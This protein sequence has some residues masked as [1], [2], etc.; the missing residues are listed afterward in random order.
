[1]ISIFILGYPQPPLG[2]PRGRGREPS[3]DLVLCYQKSYVI[4]IQGFSIVGNSK[5][6]SIFILG[7]PQPPLGRPWGRGREPRG[8]LFLYYQKSCVILIQGFSIV[9]NSKMISIFILGYPK[10]K[11][12][13]GAPGLGLGGQRWYT[14]KNQVLCQLGGFNSGDLKNYLYFHFRVLPTPT[15]APPGEG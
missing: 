2:C 5:M 1:M 12:C 10:P 15:K 11:L 8:D 3:G 4:L 7:Y 6:I 13:K 9:G 14:T